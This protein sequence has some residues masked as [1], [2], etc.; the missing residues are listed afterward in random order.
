MPKLGLV[1]GMMVMVAA[2]L[3]GGCSAGRT[4]VQQT[5]SQQLAT[6]TAWPLD[7]LAYIY[8]D[9]VAVAPI[10]DHPL[11]WV[12]YALHPI[13]VILDYAVNRPLNA[14]VLDKPGFFGV[15]SEDQTLQSQRPKFAY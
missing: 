14:Y 3:L 11:R 12:G 13:G 6:S 1:T 4:T 8:T 15:T 5:D 7:S 10:N 2:L 9:P